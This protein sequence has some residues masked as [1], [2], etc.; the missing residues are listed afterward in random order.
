MYHRTAARPVGITLG[1]VPIDLRKFKTPAFCC[2]PRRPIAPWRSTY[3]DAALFRAGQIRAV[4][5]RAISPSV[6]NPSGQQI[7]PLGE[8]RPTRR[9]PRNGSPAPTQHAEFVVAGS[10]NAD[11]EYAGGEVAD[12]PPGD[13][14][15]TSD[16]GLAGLVC[17]GPGGGLARLATHGE[18][19]GGRL[20]LA[21]LA[22][23][24]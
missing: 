12:P 1:G 20:V 17:Q 19:G 8:R 24:A 4:P 22:L 13:G 3:S 9:P 7:L 5:P 10:G 23:R 6:V 16:R 15:L 11:L 2:D 14:K 18:H 21:A